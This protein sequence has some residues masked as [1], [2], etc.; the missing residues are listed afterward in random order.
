MFGRIVK[1]RVALFW[2]DSVNVLPFLWEI[3]INYF[4]G[5]FFY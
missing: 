2:G 5:I 1:I 3:I 4:V